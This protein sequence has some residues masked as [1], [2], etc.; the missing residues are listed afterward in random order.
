MVDNCALHDK[1]NVFSAES[2][3]THTHSGLMYGGEGANTNQTQTFFFFH[4]AVWVVS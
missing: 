2:V 1:N 3:H 4:Q